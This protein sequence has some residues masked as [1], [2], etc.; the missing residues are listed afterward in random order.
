MRKRF[1]IQLFIV[2]LLLSSCG[3]TAKGVKI[4]YP[5]KV[6]SEMKAEFDL[7]ENDFEAKRYSQAQAAYQSYIQKY[8]YNA[9]TDIAEFRIG[10]IYMLKPNYEE[11]TRV[12]QALI[13]KSPDPAVAARARVKAGI[14]RYRLGDFQGALSFFD[15]ADAQ[16]VQDNDR[17]KLGGLGVRSLDK[18]NAGLERK[19]YYYAVL[20]DT[21]HTLSDASIKQQYGAEAP[22]RQEVM[23][24]LQ[25]WAQ[26]PASIGQVDSRL[27]TYKAGRSQPF[28]DYKLGMAY[29]SSGD[30][31]LA[32]K[33]LSRLVSGYPESSLAIAARPT[34]EKLGAKADKEPRP[35]GK[36]YKVGVI[37]PLTGK[38]EV[39]GKSTLN[40]MECAAS[41]KP[42][43]NGVKNIQLVVRDDRG[44]PGPAVQAV[45][46][47]V[48]TEKVMAII[49]PLSSGSAVA[50]A[51]RAQELGT[52]MISLA[53]KEGIPGTGDGIY[54]F[55]LTPKEQVD[56]L[57]RYAAKQ[58]NK[59]MVAVLYP[60]TNYGKVFL[61][62]MEAMAPNAGAQVTASRAFANTANVGDDLRQ[63]KFSVA[64]ASAQ[65]PLGFDSLFIPDSY[66]SVLK[67]LPNL[68]NSGIDNVML[69]GTN[70]W[71]DPSL[72]SK[73]GGLLGDAVFPDIYFK[74]SDS[75]LVKAFVQEYQGAF[76][77]AP[78]TLE[79]MGYDAVRFLGQALSRKKVAGSA[80]VKMAVNAM[81][82]YQGVT[83]LRA[84]E[85]DREADVEPYLLT[86]EGSTIKEIRGIE[87]RQ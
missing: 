76:G 38:Y 69:L 51:K 46:D 72:A 47:L 19:G 78:S 18:I 79:A 49:G 68:K 59:K 58:K 57:L 22:P 7:I 16:Y 70:A 27:L 30:T 9:L 74:D 66:A 37:L 20:A 44:E 53:Q 5:N 62:T 73:S 45:E 86:V 34:L 25:A 42:G 52:V 33:Y 3:L 64:K 50:A 61:S 32:R 48:Q 82:G 12:F 67:I 43:C 85:A 15:R 36:V 23:D 21:Y 39:Y 6:S 13:K 8:P 17:I 54:R 29:N 10:Q 41:T 35:S 77:Q 40:G 65:S 63:L 55:S 81:G 1:N 84:F 28:I 80:D 11:A 2:V 31:R 60:N 24:G 75:A 4:E 83:G 56:A 26:A 71:N 14:S 87:R